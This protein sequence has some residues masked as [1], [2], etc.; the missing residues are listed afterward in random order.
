MQ[1]LNWRFVNKLIAFAT[2]SVVS[3][4]PLALAQHEDALAIFT[5][6]PK[7]NTS[8]E[9]VH[10]FPTPP[11]NFDFMNATNRELLTYGLPQRPGKT[12]DAKAYEHWERAMAVLQSCSQSAQQTHSGC[13]YVAIFQGLS[14]HR[15]R[16]QTILEQEH[17]SGG[18]AG[19]GECGR[20]GR[21]HFVQLER[22]CADQQCEDLEQ[23]HV[24]RRSCFHL[25]RAGG[26][27]SVW[28]SPLFGRTVV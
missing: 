11:S 13:N 28:K 27:P 24:F 26:K 15:C 25:E 22:N 4:T 17:G 16:S 12:A 23:K 20:N 3:F 8:V 19:E 1:N 2:V 10:A 18:S 14:C 7:L 6:A 21:L 9:G 5:A